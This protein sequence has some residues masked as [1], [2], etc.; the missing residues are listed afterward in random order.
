MFKLLKKKQTNIVASNAPVPKH[1]AFICDGNRRWAEQR[2]L[3]PLMG[4]QAGIANTTVPAVFSADSC[5][6]LSHI[7]AN[8][9]GNLAR[10]PIIR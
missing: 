4:H 2:G 1:I 5:S 10:E 9:L 3:P 7:S 8:F 6:N